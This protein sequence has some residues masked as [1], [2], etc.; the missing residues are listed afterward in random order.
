MNSLIEFI[1]ISKDLR[2]K[3]SA[4]EKNFALDIAYSGN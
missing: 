2:A 4:F 1:K 3:S